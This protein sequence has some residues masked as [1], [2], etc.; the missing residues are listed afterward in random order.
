MGT[1][2]FIIPDRIEAG[3][4]HGS[5]CCYKRWCVYRSAAIAEHN[6]PFLNYNGCS[7]YRRRRRESVSSVQMSWKP[8]DVKTLPPRFPTDMQAQMTI[9]QLLLLVQAQWRKQ[10]SRT[11]SIHLEEM[12]QA[13]AQFRIDSY[14]CDSGASVLSGA[15][16]R[17]TDLACCGCVN[18]RWNGCKGYT[19]VTD[20]QFLDR[21]Y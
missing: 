16:V 18:H 6:Q 8:T 4:F 15:E 21:G 5:G 12:R 3:T 10:Y 1:I 11:V 14:S 17:A 7:I 2:Q 20:L 19:R 13:G 9:A